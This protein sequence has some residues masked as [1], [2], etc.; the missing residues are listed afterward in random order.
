MIQGKVGRSA[1][2][3]WHPGPGFAAA[4][5]PELGIADSHRDRSLATQIKKHTGFATERS[6][7]YIVF[8]IFGAGTALMHRGIEKGL[9]TVE[10]IQFHRKPCGQHGQRF[11]HRIG[12]R[13][14]A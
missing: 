10:M 7:F 12:V 1:A 2:E 3:A 11:G 14:T 9:W 13:G 4:A 6:V 5:I 8:M